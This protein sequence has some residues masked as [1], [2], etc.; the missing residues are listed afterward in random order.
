M[1]TFFAIAL[2]LSS[3]IAMADAYEDDLVKLFELTG[4]K[5]NYAGLNNVIIIKK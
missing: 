2:L 3:S 1:K 5:N 4:V